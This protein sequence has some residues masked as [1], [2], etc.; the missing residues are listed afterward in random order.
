MVAVDGDTIKGDLALQIVSK[1]SALE[2]NTKN[3]LI[4]LTDHGR[5]FESIEDRTSKGELMD[6][7]QTEQI[8]DLFKTQAEQAE[9]IKD[10]NKTIKD[11]NVTIIDQQSIIDRNSLI[12]KLMIGAFTLIILPTAFLIVTEFIIPLL[13][14]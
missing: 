7:I 8:K 13:Q 10:Q 3:I 11:Q 14:R 12:L 6:T 2:T 5:R 9:T 1:L 4:T